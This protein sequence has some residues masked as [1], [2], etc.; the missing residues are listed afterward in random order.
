[1]AQQPQLSPDGRYFWD[2]AAWRPVAAAP[3]PPRRWPWIVGIAAVALVLLGVC[4]AA[5]SDG[6]QRSAAPAAAA[7]TAVSPPVVA[8]SAAQPACA[9]PCASVD[10]LTVTV[11]GFRYGASSGNGFERPEAGNVYVT[12]QVSFVNGT[13]TE[14]HVNPYQF[15]LQDGAGVKHAIAWWMDACPVWSGVNLTAGA[16]LGPKCL[17]FQATAGSPNGLILVWTPGRSGD[18]EIPLG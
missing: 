10:G 15:V 8:P 11:G 13:P 3:R 9:P 18:H 7:L 14:Q 4:S 17:A 2:G 12:V 6:A 1:M 16:S 5:L